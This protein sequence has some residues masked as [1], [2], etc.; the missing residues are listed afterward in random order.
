MSLEREDYYVDETSRCREK[1][2]RRMAIIRAKR[3]RRNS[4]CASDSCGSI[5]HSTIALNPREQR[6]RSNRESAELS[7]RRKS[8]QI[9]ALTALVCE[10]YLELQDLYDE[11]NRLLETF[12]LYSSQ[13]VQTTWDIFPV[14]E[15]MVPCNWT[16][17]EE[18]P[19]CAEVDVK[20]IL[21]EIDEV[22]SEDLFD[23]WL[24]PIA[25]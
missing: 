12:R 5:Q 16:D 10:Y 22:L 2:K 21:Q 9:D 24:D 4:S 25:E 7:R 1:R 15:P 17:L 6:R 20:S 8:E 18:F 11:Q 14:E 13:S 19:S 23:S 3:M